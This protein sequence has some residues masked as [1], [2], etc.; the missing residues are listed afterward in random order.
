MFYETE[1]EYEVIGRE[2]FLKDTVYLGNGPL[3]KV[4]HINSVH[5]SVLLVQDTQDIR[6]WIFPPHFLHSAD[7]Q[8]RGDARQ[9]VL[10]PPA[11]HAPP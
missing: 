5:G 6:C 8:A 7:R 2:S 4:G 1:I 3:E 11:S 10:Y 9:T